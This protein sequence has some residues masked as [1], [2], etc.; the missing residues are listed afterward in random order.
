M[1]TV[2]AREFNRDVSAAKRSAAHGPVFITDRGRL[3]HVLL[4]VAEYRN[5]SGEDVSLAE[6]FCLP[7]S[8]AEERDDDFE[9]GT[10]RLHPNVP[11]L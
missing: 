4:T 7:D 11:A 6:A 3:S 1:V 8:Q 9:P 10:F 2:S 5:L